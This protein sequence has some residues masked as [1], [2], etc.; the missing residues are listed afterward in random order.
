MKKPCDWIPEEEHF[1]WVTQIALTGVLELHSTEEFLKSSLQSLESK[2][3]YKLTKHKSGQLFGFSITELL[4]TMNSVATQ[5]HSSLQSRRESNKPAMVFKHL[6]FLKRNE[7]EVHHIHPYFV[8][9]LGGQQLLPWDPQDTAMR[10]SWEQFLWANAATSFSNNVS[11]N[12]VLLL[13]CKK[14]RE[15]QT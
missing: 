2:A 8:S 14:A 13:C 15:K 9:F 4:R 7:R 5:L 11:H 10:L 3:S 12:T 6:S 1:W